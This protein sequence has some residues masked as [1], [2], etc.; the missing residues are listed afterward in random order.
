[1]PIKSKAQRRFLHWAE[2]K[3]KV[4]KG[5]AERWEEETP[6]GKSLPERLSKKAAIQL[7]DHLADELSQDPEFGQGYQEADLH[8]ADGRILHAVP[9]MNG[10]TAVVDEDIPPEDIEHIE[11]VGVANKPKIKKSADIIKY[12]K[13]AEEVHALTKREAARTQPGKKR[14]IKDIMRVDELQGTSE[15]GLGD[16]E[17]SSKSHFPYAPTSNRAS[18]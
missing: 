6:K 16:S 3:G 18:Q 17:S 15:A 8:L 12:T 10:E 13:M 1:M 14:A 2:S 9:I 11:K 7:P 5:T 4:P